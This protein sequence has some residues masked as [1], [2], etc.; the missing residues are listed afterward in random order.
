MDTYIFELSNRLD[1]SNSLYKLLGRKI[2]KIKI[3]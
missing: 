3:W 2:D 1:D